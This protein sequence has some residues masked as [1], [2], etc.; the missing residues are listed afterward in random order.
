MAPVK[1]NG[2]HLFILFWHTE[3]NSWSI[4]FFS[5]VQIK[6]HWSLVSWL[7]VETKSFAKERIGLGDHCDA[8][9]NISELSALCYTLAF[10]RNVSNTLS[11]RLYCEFILSPDTCTLH[12]AFVRPEVV[13]EVTR[14]LS[15]GM[16]QCGAADM[17]TLQT[18]LLP[19]PTDY[20]NR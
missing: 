20:V 12:K 14:L 5:N 9:G 7:L 1:L 3:F 8:A 10:R 13:K 15:F 16:W 6:Y 11:G 4:K 2:L 17:S 18:N 19:L